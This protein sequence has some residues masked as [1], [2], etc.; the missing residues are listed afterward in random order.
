MPRLPALSPQENEELFR[1]YT[2]AMNQVGGISL[3]E[4][5]KG[6]IELR[7]QLQKIWDREPRPIEYVFDDFRR[8]VMQQFLDRLR[9]QDP[10]FG[11]PQF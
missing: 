11:R 7:E 1:L 2:V 6:Q 3:K 9:S 8:S 4:V 10:R 5:R